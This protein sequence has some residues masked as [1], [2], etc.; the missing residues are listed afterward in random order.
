VTVVATYQHQTA[1]LLVADV[2]LTGDAV[3]ARAQPPIQI[4]SIDLPNV[5]NV[6]KKPILGQ[7]YV[8][9]LR[10]KIVLISPRLAV[11]WAGRFD[12]AARVIQRV[13]MT[14]CAG[15]AH[16]MIG[17]AMGVLNEVRLEAA[18]AST[19]FAVLAWHEP[20]RCWLVAGPT[21]HWMS[22]A[23]EE[24]RQF[25]D[26]ELNIANLAAFG[27]GATLAL[28]NIAGSM[29]RS[30]G[31]AHALEWTGRVLCQQAYEENGLE[32]RIGGAFQIVYAEQDSRVLRRLSS[33]L[34]IFGEARIEDGRERIRIVATTRTEYV[35]DT[36]Q[37]TGGLVGQPPSV[38]GIR[39]TTD[40]RD[41]EEVV[42]E[43]LSF[44]APNVDIGLSMIGLFI[45]VARDDGASLGVVS[46]VYS[47]KAEIAEAPF[48]LE[49]RPDLG[50]CAWRVVPKPT[51]DDAVLPEITR[52]RA[53]MAARMADG[54][55]VPA[56]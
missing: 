32:K 36:M 50:A 8:G 11:A 47:G 3:V 14:H 23:T 26:R 45:L 35:G 21:H 31:A 10:Q 24:L 20:T 52:M 54:G 49:V 4:P 38:W 51:W 30:S 33:Y 56:L 40:V 28:D 48:E 16:E 17:R 6:N 53:N 39:C 9:G 55:S 15:P 18:L 25:L 42:T 13:K 12:V 5:P 27:S 34:S 7:W 1:G 19:V 44:P 41:R 2:L 29:V 37:V 22:P 46:S 43:L